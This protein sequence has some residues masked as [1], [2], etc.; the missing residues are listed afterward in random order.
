MLEWETVCF[1]SG[2]RWQI[3]YNIYN[4]LSIFTVKLFIFRGAL[5]DT[6]FK[7]IILYLILNLCTA[8]G[9][10]LCLKQGDLIYPCSRKHCFN[11][12]LCFVLGFFFA[13]DKHIRDISPLYHT[14]HTDYWEKQPVSRLQPQLLAHRNYCSHT[15]DNLKGLMWAWPFQTRKWML[16][17]IWMESN[18]TSFSLWCGSII[19]HNWCF[20]FS[21]LSS[22]QLNK[23][24]QKRK[25][26]K[27]LHNNNNTVK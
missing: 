2:R 26:Q 8:S 11:W 18:C 24:L 17:C 7:I 16:G 3:I 12:L 27:L 10:I 25:T 5:H 19:V 15:Y 22:L 21:V 6:G 1:H 20:L 4:N 13:W 14:I 23:Y 9:F